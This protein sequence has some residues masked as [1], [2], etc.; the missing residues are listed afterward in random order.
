MENVNERPDLSPEELD[1]KRQEMLSFYNDSMVYLTAQH[2][3][4]DMLL[5]ID[6][7]RYK[8]A[9]IQVQFAMMAQAQKEAENED[10]EESFEEEVHE[11]KPPRK[12]KKQ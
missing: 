2:Q 4:E 6:E 5:K 11:E 10:I 1:Q 7:V 3:Y 12:L 9:S 8:R